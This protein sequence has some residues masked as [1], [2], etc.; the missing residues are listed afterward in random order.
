MHRQPHG[1]SVGF[2]RTSLGIKKSVCCRLKVMLPQSRH[3]HV[4]LLG[5]EFTQYVC[6]MTASVCTSWSTSI[7]PKA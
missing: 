6:V 3:S 7:W 1:N 2:K 5:S 4:E